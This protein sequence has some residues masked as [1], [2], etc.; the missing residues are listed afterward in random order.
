M[1]ES[2]SD[3]ARDSHSQSSNGLDTTEKFFD[4]EKSDITDTYSS[5]NTEIVQAHSHK[6]AVSNNN[7]EKHDMHSDNGD[8][9]I[10]PP[11]HY[12]NTTYGCRYGDECRFSHDMLSAES[13]TITSSDESDSGYD[14]DDAIDTKS[15]EYG[16]SSYDGSDEYD[17]ECNDERSAKNQTHMMKSAMETHT[18]CE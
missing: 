4:D 1:E 10:R 18:P 16:D 15:N 7:Y 13:R 9:I 3:G 2:D 6:D 14:T 12:Y 17:F 11:C 5:V 8:S